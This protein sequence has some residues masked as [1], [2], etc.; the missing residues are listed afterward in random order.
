QAAGFAKLLVIA[1]YFGAGPSLDAYYLGSVIPTFLAGIS[2]GILQTGFVPAYVRA[3]ARGHDAS[4]RTL[5]NVTLTWAVLA[6]SVVAALLTLMRAEAVP[7]T[8][9]SIS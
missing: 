2:A 4:A 6:L 7:V 9:H 3:R 5:A 1:D 8:A